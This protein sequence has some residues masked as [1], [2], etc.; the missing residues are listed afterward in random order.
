M[1]QDDQIEALNEALAD[2]PSAAD[3]RGGEDRR[4]GKPNNYCGPERRG[5]R[6]RR[7]LRDRRS[8]FD[9]RRDLRRKED[10]AAFQ[11][12]VEEGD[13]TLE[14]IEFVRAI[15]RYKQKFNRPFPT[16]SEVLA[17][18]KELGYTKDSLS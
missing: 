14:E 11:K 3:R 16:W 2:Q 4:S 17:I 1:A 15:D 5:S 8:G 9:R 13:L 18:V 6:D 12:R 7:V 10:Q